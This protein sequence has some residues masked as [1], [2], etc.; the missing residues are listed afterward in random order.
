MADL[1]LP[2]DHMA[3]HLRP[4]NAGPLA[5]RGDRDGVVALLD[6]TSNETA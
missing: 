4:V 2:G 6:G 3:E 5:A 1:V